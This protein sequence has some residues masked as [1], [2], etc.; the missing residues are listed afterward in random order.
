MS[1]APPPTP[2]PTGT[3]APDTVLCDRYRLVRLLAIGGMAEVWSARDELL[4]RD[5]AVKVL[6]RH[7]AADPGFVD[8]FRSEAV[9]AA[10]LHHPGIVA[11]FD[12]CS[13]AGLEAIVLELVRGHTLRQHL[14]D[15]V[16]LPV[17]DAVDIG[18]SVAEALDEAHRNGL[19]HRDVKPANV[20][21]CDDDR[22][23]ITDFGIAKVVDT[24]DRTATGTMLGSVKYLSPEQVEGR[25]VDGRSDVFSLGVVLWECLTG[26]PPW[27]ESTPAATALA[28]LHLPPDDL[29][30]ER[31][32]APV[33]LAR[34]IERCLAV[35]VDARPADAAEVAT[36]LSMI[37]NGTPLPD[38]GRAETARAGDATVVAPAPVR[39]A[40]VPISAD[41]D[42]D[43]EPE[44]HRRHGRRRWP[45]ALAVT[46]LVAIGL[47]VTG[48]L[49]RDTDQGRDLLDRVGA[50]DLAPVTERAITAVTPF[51]P[52][53]TGTPGERD[54]LAPL[55]HDG[56]PATSWQSEGYDLRT[57]GTKRGVGLAIELAE[58]TP[59]QTVV[60]SSPTPGWSATV[61]VADEPGA[62]I[63]AWG[64][65]VGSVTGA[66]GAAEIDLDG[67]E[68]RFVLV[69]FTDLGEPEPGE[70]ARVVVEELVV[71]G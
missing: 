62:T 33:D 66:A 58:P 49:L 25:P 34:L 10:R 15:E 8:R 20:L 68:G 7:L 16:R 4:D 30:A 54:D 57:F 55:A 45:A 53:G 35:D 21:L 22:V 60:V 44:A 65:P 64:D 24:T 12:T 1:D 70:R 56:D 67:T 32:D 41:V 51:D 26:R 9:A 14:D 6:H 38:D 19:V 40:P 23:L 71:R 61:H 46:S 31:P 27:L 52:E 11:V 5:V 39:P 43:D 48:L 18:R 2:L 59:V 63:E 3:A 37:G 29:R 17:V 13:D 50:G 42:E 28:R 69:W 36:A 47:V